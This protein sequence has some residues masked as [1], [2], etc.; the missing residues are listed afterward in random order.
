MVEINRESAGLTRL[1]VVKKSVILGEQL[2]PLTIDIPQ[3]RVRNAL[4]EVTGMLT[5]RQKRT[6]KTTYMVR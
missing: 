6:L 5:R 2:T 1:E 3:D 4:P